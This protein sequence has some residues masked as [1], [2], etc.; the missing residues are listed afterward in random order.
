MLLLKIQ[1]QL[2]RTENE[3]AGT[4]MKTEQNYRFSLN[5]AARSST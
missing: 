2:N 4:P 3:I 5:I 1:P